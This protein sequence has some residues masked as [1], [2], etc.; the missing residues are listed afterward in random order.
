MIS[1]NM[2][3]ISEFNKFNYFQRL[4]EIEISYPFDIF[5]KIIFRVL[6]KKVYHCYSGTCKYPFVMVRWY[7]IVISKNSNY[8]N[9]RFCFHAWYTLFIQLKSLSYYSK[10]IIMKAYLWKLYSDHFL[11]PLAIYSFSYWIPRYNINEEILPLY[12]TNS[13]I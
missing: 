2:Y 5:L 6:Y 12:F 8:N 1:L 11:F 13:L 7:S 4:I 9:E 3:V 10:K